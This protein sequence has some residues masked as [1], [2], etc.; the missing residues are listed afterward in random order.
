MEIGF[1]QKWFRA[2]ATGIYLLC[3]FAAIFWKEPLW[4]IAPLFMLIAKPFAKWVTNQTEQLY[5]LYLIVLPLSTEYNITPSLALDLPGE[6]ILI[7]L[8]IFLIGNILS[9]PL[10]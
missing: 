6:P 10:S 5:W 3:C 2:M 7:G 1:P 9:Q 4:M 8:T